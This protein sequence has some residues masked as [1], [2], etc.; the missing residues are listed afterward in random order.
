MI[1]V[2]LS[3]YFKQ[4]KYGLTDVDFFSES[5]KQEM[6]FLDLMRMCNFLKIFVKQNALR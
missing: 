4:K 3:G 2:V 6:D 5:E 1:K